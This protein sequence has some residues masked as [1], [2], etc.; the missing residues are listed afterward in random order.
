MA[1]YLNS[2]ENSKMDLRSQESR[3]W[4]LTRGNHQL[5]FQYHMRLAAR[6]DS[7]DISRKRL[8][9]P[10]GCCSF[11]VA[12]EEQFSLIVKAESHLK[13]VRKIIHSEE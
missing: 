3:I 2:V 7:I 12:G 4:Q 6:F 8:L 13:G 1:T 5:K 9:F 10:E 11:E